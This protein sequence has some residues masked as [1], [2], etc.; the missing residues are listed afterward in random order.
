MT[1]RQA[2]WKPTS[3]KERAPRL[4]APSSAPSGSA[5]SRC[6]A[7][8]RK[9]VK[10]S[11]MGGETSPFAMDNRDP[12][13]LNPHIQILWD[14]IIGEPEGLRTPE[15]CW[16]CSQSCYNKTRRCCYVF[17]VVLL[18]PFVAFCNGCQFACLAFNQVWCV[19]PCLRCVKIN[20]ATVKKFWEA[21]LYAICSPLA[22]VC[23]MYFSKIHVR[24]QRVPDGNVVDSSGYF[25]V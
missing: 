14:D 23:G 3:R 19:G 11:R 24:Y 20:Y 17:L 1:Q 5:D 21:C 9:S 22:E 6:D 13:N 15:G 25:N 8:V 4:S 18:A 7:K 10:G 2:P 12:N 16:N